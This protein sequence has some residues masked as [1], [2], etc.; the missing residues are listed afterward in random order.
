MGKTV[1]RHLRRLR[2]PRTYLFLEGLENRL[3]PSASPLLFQLNEGQFDS[4][5]L[6]MAQGDNFQLFL[7][8]KAKATV[9]MTDSG[10]YS[11]AGVSLVAALRGASADAQAVGLDET[12]NAVPLSEIPVTLAP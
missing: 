6:F 8:S 3:A 2:P 12:D 10:G 1:R 11:A 9:V 7:G 4:K 5:Q